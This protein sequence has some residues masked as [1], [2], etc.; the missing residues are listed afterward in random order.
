MRTLFVAKVFLAASAFA[1]TWTEYPVTFPPTITAITDLSVNDAGSGGALPSG[2]YEAVGPTLGLNN[3]TWSYYATPPK[4]I[5]YSSTADDGTIYAVDGGTSPSY[6]WRLKLPGSWEIAAYATD[7]GFGR[8]TGVAGVNAN[9]WWAV[10][11]GGGA[12]KDDGVVYFEQGKP[13]KV[14][15]FG[16]TTTAE[17]FIVIP[18]VADP[19]GEAY[20]ML[21]LLVASYNDSR[22]CLFVLNPSGEYSGYVAPTGNMVGCDGLAAYQPGDVRLMLTPYSS[23]ASLL[24]KFSN[25]TFTLLETFPERVILRSYPSP[26][27]GWGTTNTSKVYHWTDAGFSSTYTLP[28][29]VLDLDFVNVNDGWAVGAYGSGSDR[30]PKMWHYTS[31]GA[32]VVPSSLG[33]VKAAFK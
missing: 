18:R 6:L 10:A 20:A 5:A 19:T 21:K 8:F 26:S 1:G 7:Y 2:P 24:Y 28:G 32:T 17:H 14:W 31:S 12:G 27:E 13:A 4:R 22:W 15:K 23:G 11:D 25:G 30:V 16:D 9:S 3:G 29:D 33:R